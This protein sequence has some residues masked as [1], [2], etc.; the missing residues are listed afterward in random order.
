METLTAVAAVVIGWFL[1]EATF[2]LRSRGQRLES[3]GRLLSELLEIRHR[4]VT[5]ELLTNELRRR[6]VLTAPQ[7]ALFK[8]V[9]DKLFPPDPKLPER[10]EAAI[11]ALAGL[12]PLLAFEF[13]S[14]EQ[15]P[16]LLATLRATQVSVAET[17]NAGL[18]LFVEAETFLYG[19]G[20]KTIENA[21]RVLAIRHGIVTAV[22][23]SRLLARKPE[24]PSSATEYI[25]RVVAAAR[26]ME[27]AASPNPSSEG[28]AAHG[29]SS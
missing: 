22:R 12:Q 25:D 21:I 16:R 15:L 17:P 5:F 9:L 18:N 14:K 4:I 3:I 1:N 19:E 6:V 24:F 27:S 20:V 10:Y 28:P 13:R 29:A 26:A 7:T 23:I 8:S 2:W 11:E